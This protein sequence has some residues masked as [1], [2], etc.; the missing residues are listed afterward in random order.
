MKKTAGNSLKSSRLKSPATKFSW[1]EIGLIAHGLTRTSWLL[2]GV[3]A[4]I[5]KEYRLGPRGGW[6]LRMIDTGQVIYP[7][8]VTNFFHI[9]R[10]V[11]TEELAVLTERRLIVYRKSKEDGRRVKLALTGLGRKVSLRVQEVLSKMITQRFSGYSRA[12]VL[13]F[14]GILQA[15]VSYSNDE[16]RCGEQIQETTNDSRRAK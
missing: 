1:E 14:A 7:L 5:T 12:E 6:I 8:D 15:F 13:Q 2:K 16:A 4:D 11:I 10:S 3:I 9:S